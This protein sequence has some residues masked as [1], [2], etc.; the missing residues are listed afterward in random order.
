MEKS[1]CK[2]IIAQVMI[3]WKF[4]I[5]DLYIIRKFLGTYFYSIILICTIAVVFDFAENIDK[6]IDNEA[7][8]KA[9]IFDYYLNFIPYFA[10]LFSSLFTFISVI[11]FTSKMAYDTEIIAILSNGVS[12]RRLLIP[13][14]LSALVI[15]AFSFLLSDQVLPD[16]N[17]QRLNFEQL[18]RRGGV[19]PYMERDIH[20]Q[21]APGVFIYM[22]NYSNASDIGYNF[23]MERF[24]NG[25]MV[26]KLISD[27]VRWDS[28]INKW[29]IRNYYIREI[30]G[31]NEHITSGVQLD[32]VINIH[33]SDF[34]R[35]EKIVETMSLAEL[36]DFIAQQRMQGAE[37]I[38]TYLIEKH[39]R[40]AYPFSTFILTVIGMAVSSRKVKGGIGLHIGTGLALS[41]SYILFMRFTT[42]FA[43]SGLFSPLVAVWIPNVAYGIIAYFL[44][45]MAPK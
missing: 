44:Y 27:Y 17:A 20:K 41:F 32:T 16:A 29:S 10:I 18:Y 22:S 33:P 36:N 3:R 42:M 37:N 4:K 30:E 21:I 28:V 35:L 34:A 19:Q 13:Y 26:W 38:N 12:F 8:V 40:I 25:E 1:D 9:V 5:L 39:S 45:R 7:P 6:F 31:L 23:S 24:E 11:F 14:F 15:A 43:I 2:E